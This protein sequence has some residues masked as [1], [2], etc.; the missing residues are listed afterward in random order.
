MII[1]HH[2]G[3]TLGPFSPTGIFKVALTK[4]GHFEL[5]STARTVRNHNPVCQESDRYVPRKTLKFQSACFSLLQAPSSKPQRMTSLTISF[6]RTVFDVCTGCDTCQ[7][8][9]ATCLNQSGGG[10]PGS[11]LLGGDNHLRA[12]LPALCPAALASGKGV[13]LAVTLAFRFCTASNTFY[14]W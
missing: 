8:P 12:Q 5:T 4:P 11:C 1:T 9:S 6:L 3:G 13:I 2:G 7:E 10:I 14:L